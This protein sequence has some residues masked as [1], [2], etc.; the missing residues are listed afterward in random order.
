MIFLQHFVAVHVQ[1][2][3]KLV[4]LN[5][6]VHLDKKFSSLIFYFYFFSFPR[7]F[8]SGW[9]ATGFCSGWRTTGLFSG[10]RTTGFC[11]EWRTTGFRSEWRTTGFCSKWRTANEST[12]LKLLNLTTIFFLICVIF[13]NVYLS[14]FT[15]VCQLLN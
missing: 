8:C 13:R 14:S 1:F 4:F 7:G 11:S 12:S 2:V 9:R 3:K 15:H 6:E 5:V 10:W